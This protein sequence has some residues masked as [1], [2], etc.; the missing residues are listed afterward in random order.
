MTCPGQRN[1]GD[2]SS[3]IDVKFS[4]ITKGLGSIGDTAWSKFKSGIHALVF[5]RFNGKENT[6]TYYKNVYPKNELKNAQ[7]N[8]L[9]M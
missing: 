5:L 1:G 4:M 6:Y 3:R 7:L 8:V 2:H 9:H